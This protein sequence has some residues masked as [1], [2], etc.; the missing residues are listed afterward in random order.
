MYG[1]NR[2]RTKRAKHDARVK[3]IT[4]INKKFQ[5]L[6]IVGSKNTILKV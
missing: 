5:F 2:T 1:M 3:K 6:I 4:K